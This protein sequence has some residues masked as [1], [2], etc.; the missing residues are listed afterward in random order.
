[1][2]IGCSSCQARFRLDRNRVGGKRLTLKCP[3]CGE[4]FKVDVP[5]AARKN[6]SVLVAHGDHELCEAIGEILGRDSIPY[7]SCHHSDLALKKLGSGKFPVAVVDVALPGIFSF[8]L[9]EQ[10]KGW[11]SPSP[12]KIILLS[13][14]YNRTAYKRLPSSLYGADDYI[15]KHHMGDL[16][17]PKILLLGGSDIEKASP[18]PK[19]S[20]EAQPEEIPHAEAPEEPFLDKIN[21]KIRG[22]EEHEVAPAPTGAPEALEKAAR[23]AR[24]IVSDIALYNQVRVD[25]GVTQGTFFTL[26]EHDIQEGRRLYRERYASLDPNDRLLEKAFEVFIEKRRGELLKN[27]SG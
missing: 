2:V 10:V 21:E 5:P 26:L 6:F 12:P 8:Q 15:E 19:A 9:V 17:V 18:S 11:G 3:R 23:L 1:M 22:A 7:E 13:S 4:V 25:E 24:I 16:L 14:V 27:S 20:G